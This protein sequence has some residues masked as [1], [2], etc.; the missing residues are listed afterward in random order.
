MKEEQLEQQ[1]K[2]Q[3]VRFENAVELPFFNEETGDKM[4]FVSDGIVNVTEYLKAP[5]KILWILKE[6]NSSEDNSLDDMRPCLKELYDNNNNIDRDWG[7]TWQKV[8]YCTYGIFEHLKFEDIPEMQGNAREVLKYMP[9]IAHINVKK[10]AGGSSADDKKIQSFYNT[11]KDFLHEQIEIINPDILIFGSTFGYFAEYFESKEKIQ[12]RIP[13]YQY[14]DKLLI[15]TYH[16]NARIK[17]DEY[18]NEIINAV[19]S[20]RMNVMCK[21]N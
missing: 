8:A 7:R 1:I 3:L 6:A 19:N 10:Y 2:E 18:C 9:S 16:P 13:V 12:E 14:K 15:D 11:Y 4:K 21:E 17:Q 5:I 20:W